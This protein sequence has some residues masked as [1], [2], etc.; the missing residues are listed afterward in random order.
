M[1]TTDTCPGLLAGLLIGLLVESQ[2]AVRD[3]MKKEPLEIKGNSTYMKDPLTVLCVKVQ[4]ESV[5]DRK[6]EKPSI[7]TSPKHT[8]QGLVQPI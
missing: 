5:I 7:Q 3:V 6:D 8:Q 2:Q 4:T 1:I